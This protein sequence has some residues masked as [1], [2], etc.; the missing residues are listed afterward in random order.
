M[1]GKTNNQTPI[2][3]LTYDLFLTIL[4]PTISPNL[5]PISDYFEKSKFRCSTFYCYS[6]LPFFSSNSWTRSMTFLT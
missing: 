4:S 3:S 1:E 2:V 6:A 5:F